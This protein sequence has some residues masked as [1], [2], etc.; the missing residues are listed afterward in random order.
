MTFPTVESVT[1]ESFPTD[2]T[3]H[4]VN[5]PATVNAGDLLILIFAS[6]GLTEQTAPGG[7]STLDKKTTGNQVYGGVYALKAAGTEGGGSADVVTASAE[8]GSGH[9]YRITG[10]GG[11]LLTDVD[12]STVATG[13]DSSPNSGSVTAGWGSDDNL[14]LSI[15]CFGDDDEVAN[16]APAPNYTNLVSVACGA[17]ANAS[18]VSA[19]A[20]RNYAN[21]SDDPTA[22]VLTG[23][24]NWVAWTVVIKPDSGTIVPKAMH[25]YRNHGKI[26]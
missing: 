3:S 6:D 23:T 13:A 22:F 5:M 17:G 1:E 14:F 12:I 8:A 24:E 16:T 2:T 18:A 7:W 4:N 21:A 9:V 15:T 19:S 10:W 26:F 11:T 20:R 25:H